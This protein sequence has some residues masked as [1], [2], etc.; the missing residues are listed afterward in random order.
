MWVLSTLID[1][2]Y[3]HRL[4]GF[5]SMGPHSGMVYNGYVRFPDWVTILRAHGLTL[6][7]MQLLE[8]NIRVTRAGRSSKDF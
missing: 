6:D 8:R 2:V 1:L 4:G 7:I 5:Y 3:Y